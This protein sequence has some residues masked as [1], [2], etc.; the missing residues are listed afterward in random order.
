RHPDTGLLVLDHLADHERP[1]LLPRHERLAERLSDPRHFVA[2]RRARGGP[3]CHVFRFSRPVAAR[4]LPGLDQ[5]HHPQLPP[6]SPSTRAGPPA[7]LSRRSLPGRAPRRPGRRDV[8]RLALLRR[9]PDRWPELGLPPRAL[10][11]S[12]RVRAPNRRA[13]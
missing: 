5:S 1:M 11:G 13:G 8:G 9:A 7:T 3:R 2:P 6:E 10:A 12:A 4:W